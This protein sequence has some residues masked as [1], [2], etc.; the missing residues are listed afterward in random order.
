MN[1]AFQL[2][3]RTAMAKSY[4]ASACVALA[5]AMLSLAPFE[6]AARS[7]GRGLSASRGGFQALRH[8]GFRAH[9]PR[10]FRHWP[11]WGGYIA[12]LPSYDYGPDD[13][14]EFPFQ[15]FVA[16]PPPPP[17]SLDCKRSRTTVTVPSEAGGTREIVVTRC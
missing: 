13:I 14:G 9:R 5:L 2:S 7:G 10:G 15:L 4:V 16:P 8:G 17:R 6:A 1:N 12:T 11:L 3:W